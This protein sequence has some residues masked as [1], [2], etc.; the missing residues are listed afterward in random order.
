MSIC[1]SGVLLALARTWPAHSMTLCSTWAFAAAP[2][3]TAAPAV[4]LFGLEAV[5]VLERSVGV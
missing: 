5:G 2:T 4:V 1:R 3:M